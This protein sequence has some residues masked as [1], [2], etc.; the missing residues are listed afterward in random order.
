MQNTPWSTPFFILL[1]SLVTVL[2]FYLLHPFLN[3]L[4][5]AA[6]IS[7]VFHPTYRYCRVSWNMRPNVASLLTLTLCVV[8]VVI[9]LLFIFSSLVR[10]GISLYNLIQ[11]GEIN[12]LYYAD[13]LRQ[14]FPELREFLELFRLDIDELRTKA[15][16]W[17][18][19]MG[20]F[21]AR[22]AMVWGS[23][24]LSVFLDLCLVLY[25]AFFL[26]REGPVMV[27]LLAK[28]I[29]LGEQREKLL[30]SK[31]SEVTRATIKGSLVVAVVQ[32]ALGG[33][34]FWILG[35][36]GP[37]LWGVVMAVLSLLPVV[38]SGLIWLPVAIALL[39][40]G[41]W[42]KGSVLVAFGV[43]VIGLVDNLLRPFL[44]GR[45]TK[46]PDY[47]VLLSTLGGFVVF[48]FSGFIAGP[49]VAVL[50][51]TFWDI[52]AREVSCENGKDTALQ[53]A[54]A[55]VKSSHTETEKK[56]PKREKVSRN[57][58]FNSFDG[59]VER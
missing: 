57:R 5:W 4:F 20:G 16:N 56:L 45:D 36:S 8:V 15:T 24:T 9:P 59:S 28:A 25:L 38:G 30:F 32:G 23:G 34:I 14:A 46:L 1:L 51:L 41:E 19:S 55:Q 7:L 35:I 11:R 18:V 50:F 40:S 22:N 3:V 44:V 12:P 39:V 53:N 42:M 2:F 17:I 29:P 52:F 33:L 31:F 47:M 37:I 6:A 13:Q 48:G 54:P 27:E 43:G 58:K 10:E 49:L 21:L 26:L